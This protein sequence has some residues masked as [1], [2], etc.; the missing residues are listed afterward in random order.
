[1]E[2]FIYFIEYFIIIKFK[3]GLIAICSSKAYV[4]SK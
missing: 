2:P 4:I 1:M 3:F